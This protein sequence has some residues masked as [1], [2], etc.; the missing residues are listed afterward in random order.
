MHH[1]LNENSLTDLE[2]SLGDGLEPNVDGDLKS[3]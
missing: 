3:R 1:M 2:T